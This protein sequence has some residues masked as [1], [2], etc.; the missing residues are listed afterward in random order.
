MM[1]AGVMEKSAVWRQICGERETGVSWTF[2]S[3]CVYV[4]VSLHVSV[5][6]LVCMHACTHVCVSL[7]TCLYLCNV[8]V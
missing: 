1:C 4:F 5:C 3:K 7:S 6:M 2:V 8:Y